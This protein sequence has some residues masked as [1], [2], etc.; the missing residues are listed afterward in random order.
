MTNVVMGIIRLLH[1][2]VICWIFW[3][4]VWLIIYFQE[5]DLSIRT[6]MTVTYYSQQVHKNEVVIWSITKDLI[7]FKQLLEDSP[8]VDNSCLCFGNFNNIKNYKFYFKVRLYSTIHEDH[9]RTEKGQRIK[10]N[11]KYHLH[12]SNF[13]Q[14]L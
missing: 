11:S 10:V 8:R 4:K 3:R 12:L 7:Q 2:S 14:C 9:S 1:S 5:L 6:I 13:T